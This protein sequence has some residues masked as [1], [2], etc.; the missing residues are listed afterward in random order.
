[1]ISLGVIPDCFNTSLL[2]LIPKNGELRSPSDYRPISVSTSTATLF[3][4]LLLDKIPWIKAP[5]DNQFGY[6]DKTFCKSAFFV[7]NE[8]NRYYKFGGSYMHSVSL[9]AAKTF[10]KL[11]RNGVFFKL[12]DHISSHIWRILYCYYKYS[13]IIVNVEGFVT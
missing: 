5:N 4:I 10:D 2:I 6:K 9:D 8:T 7:A 12:I 11:W 1:M 13:Y 3:E